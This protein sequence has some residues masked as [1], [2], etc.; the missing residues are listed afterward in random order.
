MSFG[1]A[2]NEIKFKWFKKLG[3][4]DRIG[5]AWLRKLAELSVPDKY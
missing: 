5:V 1:E 4:D 3:S 2:Y